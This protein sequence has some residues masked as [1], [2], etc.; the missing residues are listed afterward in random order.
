MSHVLE[1]SLD[2][3]TATRAT[4][5]LLCP[6]CDTRVRFTI[7]PAGSVDFLVTAF[8]DAHVAHREREAD[9]PSVWR[10]PMPDSAAMWD[11][12]D[13]WHNQSTTGEGGRCPTC[14]YEE[15]IYG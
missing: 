6:D 4:V 5:V 10:G 15:V 3:R 9:C 7:E 8:R 11:C 1:V 12:E 2:T 14:K 13:P